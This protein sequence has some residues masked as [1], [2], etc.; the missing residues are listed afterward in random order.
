MSDSAAHK[1]V[2]PFVY[3]TFTTKALHFSISEIQSRMDIRQ[4]DALNLEYT[5]T[6]MGFLLFEPEPA[7]IA[8]IGLGGGSLAKFCYRHLPKT[9]IR[10]IEI[11]PHVIAL[12]EEFQVPP[13]CERF[14]V[15]QGDGAE[16]VRFPPSRFDVLLVDGYDNKGLP[17]RLS[18]KNFYDDCFE[19]LMPGGILV[20]NLHFDHQHYLQQVERIRRSFSD[21]ILVVDDHERGNSVVFAENGRSPASLRLGPLR[22]PRSLDE[23]AWK[24]LQGAFARI[25]SALKE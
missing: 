24:S 8:M 23:A 14:S 2:K 3:K 4:P 1:H 20:V 12:R 16:F 13:D 10:V 11:N 21:A 6:M 5:R 19:M 18:S 25:L 9:N 17:K 15:I 7:N 22:R